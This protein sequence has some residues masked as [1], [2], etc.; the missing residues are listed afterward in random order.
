MVDAVNGASNHN[1]QAPPD[2]SVP[3]RRDAG[4]PA[5]LIAELIAIS[6]RTQDS[7]R[8]SRS[9]NRA[10]RREANEKRFE[11]MEDAADARFAAGVTS[12]A[13]QAASAGFGYAQSAAQSSQASAQAAGDTAAATQM[14]AR[15]TSFQSTSQAVGATGQLLESSFNRIATGEDI[16]AARYQE[17]AQS[18]SERADEASEDIRRAQT[19]QD[20]ALS[21]LADISQARMQA[22]ITA[23]RG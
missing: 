18:A 21:H 17:A 19:R 15:S 16:E 13:T 11:A 23:S 12:G 10:M 5:V 6:E 22:Q 1:H 2:D 20:K 3:I 14:Q 8:A 4:D 7:A 9:A